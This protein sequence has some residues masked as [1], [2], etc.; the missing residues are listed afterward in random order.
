MPYNPNT[1]IASWINNPWM[2]MAGSLVVAPSVKDYW[3]QNTGFESSEELSKAKTG[4]QNTLTG[5]GRKYGLSGLRG[6]MYSSMASRGGGEIQFGTS[7]QERTYGI[8]KG[9]EVGNE[10]GSWL[11]AVRQGKDVGATNIQGLESQNKEFA[12]QNY[13]NKTT[14]ITNYYNN[15]IAKATTDEDYDK[16][17]TYRD[18][19]QQSLNNLQSA[20]NNKTFNPSATPDMYYMKSDWSNW[21]WNGTSWSTNTEETEETEETGEIE[22]VPVNSP[23]NPIQP[24][25]ER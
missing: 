2:K 16:A 10:I 4:Y 25:K 19:M 1:G 14:E 17:N 8:E 9:V 3:L 21:Y 13:Q 6:Q 5:I 20:W 7:G 15:L 24:Y 12:Y 22:P 23:D 11:D 18:Q